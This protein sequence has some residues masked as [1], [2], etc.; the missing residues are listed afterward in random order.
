MMNKSCKTIM[1]RTYYLIVLIS[2]ARG[3]TLG[4]G[5]MGV[6]VSL[7]SLFLDRCIVAKSK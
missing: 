2:Y 6:I 5:H 4:C 3:V 7:I 1:S